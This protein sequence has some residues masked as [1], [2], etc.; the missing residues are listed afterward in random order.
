MRIP[1]SM[2]VTNSD[3]EYLKLHPL[4]DPASCLVKKKYDFLKQDIENKN[5]EWILYITARERSLEALYHYRGTTEISGIHESRIEIQKSIS[6]ECVLKDKLF[7]K[8]K[9]DLEQVE[10]SL[11]EKII[12]H[13]KGI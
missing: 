13:M 3:L 5:K 1:Q 8:L 12:N 7:K 2:R 11:K 4:T 10:R 6:R 9:K